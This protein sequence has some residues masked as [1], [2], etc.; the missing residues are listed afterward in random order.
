MLKHGTPLAFRVVN[1]VSGHLLNCVCNLWLFPEDATELSVPLRVVTSSAGLPSK[2]CLGIG[3][4][5]EWTGKSVS[6][7][8]CH[9]T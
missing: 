4:Y 6:F 1:G 7:R 8:I 9:D 5:L 2:R 3:S